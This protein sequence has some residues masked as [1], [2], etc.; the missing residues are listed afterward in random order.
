MTLWATLLMVS[1][2]SQGHGCVPMGAFI[3][4]AYD[5]FD[6][7]APPSLAGLRAMGL[8]RFRVQFLFFH[9]L[10]FLGRASYG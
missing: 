6:R 10:I 7:K 4:A 5:A 1:N 2:S 9:Y 8:R 3:A